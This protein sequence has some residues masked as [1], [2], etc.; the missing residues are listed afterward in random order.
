ML[1]IMDLGGFSYAVYNKALKISG[2]QLDRISC[3]A[4]YEL[5]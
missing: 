4:T 3:A 2:K 5:E 1:N